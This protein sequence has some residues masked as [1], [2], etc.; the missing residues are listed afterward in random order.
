MVFKGRPIY[1]VR[2]RK[3]TNNSTLEKVSRFK[4]LGCEVSYKYK[5]N[6]TGKT[7]KFRNI[8][9]MLKVLE[10]KEDKT[11]KLNFIRQLQYLH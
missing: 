3:V 1:P 2:T 5:S 9:G 11:Q 8:S 7:N 10:L 4:Y 6:I